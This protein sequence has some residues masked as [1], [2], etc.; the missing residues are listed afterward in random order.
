VAYFLELE[1]A[2]SRRFREDSVTDMI[3]GSLLQ[4]GGA[5]VSVLTPYEP[6]S[7]SDFDIAIIDLRSKVAIQYRIQAKRLFPNVKN[8]KLGSYR[9]L[10]HPHGTGKQARQ[11][12]HSSAHERIPT[13]PLYAFYNPASVCKAS[14][15]TVSGIQLAD[16]YAV[17]AAVEAMLAAKPKR[18]PLKRIEFMSELFFP[19]AAIL[20]PNGT[21]RLSEEGFV[22]PAL[23]KA[24]VVKTMLGQ[25]HGSS[26]MQS[27]PP[28]RWK[29][30]A[31]DG[32]RLESSLLSRPSS[33]HAS[34]L[35]SYVRQSIERRE[36][37]RFLRA[38]INR[39]KLVFAR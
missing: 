29:Q 12:L 4:V 19:L 9:E 32:R 5:N 17:R 31:L 21:S 24:F 3:I 22:N 28:S 34:L 27:L 18:L 26:W 35:P 20:C 36:T 11:L 39:P 38:P 23:S 25:V 15:G 14:G 16:A 33:D 10:S 7:G 13:I 30:I 37:V 6:V 8:W 2:V 1:N